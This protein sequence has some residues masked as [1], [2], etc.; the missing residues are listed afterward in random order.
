[1]QTLFA[2]A[3]L[4][5][6]VS[7]AFVGLSLATDAAVPPSFQETF[8]YSFSN[9]WCEPNHLSVVDVDGDGR[10]DILLM[11]TALATPVGPPWSYKGRVTLL[12][13]QADGGYVASTV[14]DFPG[15]Y[16]YNIATGDLNNDGSV[17]FVV[18]PR[19]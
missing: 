11:T 7:V 2:R 9:Y 17:D 18:R 3:L 10:K 16:G 14:A 5:F 13:G 1:M 19:R 15:D 12:R 4:A 8:S 6:F